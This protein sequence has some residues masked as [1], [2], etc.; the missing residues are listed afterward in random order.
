MELK[1]VKIEN[2][3]HLNMILGQTHFIKSVEDI[4]EAVVTTVPMAKFGLA[5]CEA[6]DVC[7]VRYTGTD[8]KLV[9]LAKTNA[10]NL[11]AGH[12]FIMFMKDMFPINI[13]NTIQNVPEVCGIFCA[14][15]NPVE[16]VIAQTQQGR[17]ILGVID[18]FA[19][20]GIETDADIQKRKDFLRMIGYKQ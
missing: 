14:T 15:A 12:C 16:V 1:T 19:S 3:D 5:F 20:K 17:G 6:S 13:L 7:L 8:D 9:E 11:S 18:G 2:P 10:Y 4:H